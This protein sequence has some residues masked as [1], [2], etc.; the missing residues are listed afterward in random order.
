MT[1][2]ILIA[3]SSHDGQT[4]RI[5]HRLGERLA[6]RD[7]P[8]DLVDLAARVCTP[9]GVR[10]VVLGASLRYG[11]FPKVVRRWAKQHSQA[12]AQLPGAFFAVSLAAASKRPEDAGAAERLRDDMIARTGWKPTLRASFAGALRYSAYGPLTRLIMRRIA[13]RSGG[14]TDLS[15][16]HDYTD[17]AAV[18]AFADDI[19]ALFTAAHRAA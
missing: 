7:L 11:R 12:L 19:A 18:D 3:F 2:P 16:D 15:R 4:G 1:A 6:A 8:V 9:D 10:G 14:D 5:A 17:W 13:G